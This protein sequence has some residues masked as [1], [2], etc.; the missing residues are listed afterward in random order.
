[1]RILGAHH[2]QQFGAHDRIVYRLR[3]DHADAT[4]PVWIIIRH[5]VLALDG[6]D[7]R[8]L[9]TVGQGPQLRRG[10]MAAGPAHDE[11]AAGRVYPARDTGYILRAHRDLRARPQ[12]VHAGD[13]AVGS[14]QDDVLRQCEM[15]DAAARVGRGDRLMD[16]GG[17]LLRRIGSFRIERHI[18]KQ[19]IW[20]GGLDVIDALHFARHVAGERE[21]GRVVPRRFVKASDQMGAAWPR[22]A[23]A[24][25]K[26][27]GQLGLTRRRQ[28]RAFF[29][30]NANPFD[31]R[32]SQG[33]GQRIERVADQRENLL[34]ADAFKNTNQCIR[35][36]LSHVFPTYRSG[37]YRP[38][39]RDGPHGSF[40]RVLSKSILLRQFFKPRSSSRMKPASFGAFSNNVPQGAVKL[41]HFGRDFGA[42][43]QARGA[44]LTTL[45][46]GVIG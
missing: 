29:M 10:P 3:T 16:D 17:G 15:S 27:A 9:E 44:A 28:S 5:D 12:S 37:S 20:I 36:R 39:P 46:R 25:R 19:Q 21:H 31:G 6:M 18:A 45:C 32:A 34:D 38:G 2:Q 14:R 23:G 11:N 42:R 43:R 22:G 33:I 35:D 4:H 8:R 13:A 7:Q 41:T 40:N 26:T 30:A 24:D 1:M